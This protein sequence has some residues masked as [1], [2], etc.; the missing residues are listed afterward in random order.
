M[1]WY[2]LNIGYNWI[3]VERPKWFDRYGRKTGFIVYCLR[4]FLLLNWGRNLRLQQQEF[5][6]MCA[7]VFA[8]P[9]EDHYQ[10]IQI[11]PTPRCVS[12]GNWFLVSA[13]QYNSNI[14]L[15]WNNEPIR[16]YLNQLWFQTTIV[17]CLRL[18]AI[19]EIYLAFVS[20]NIHC[21]RKRGSFTCLV[22]TFLVHSKISLVLS[23]PVTTHAK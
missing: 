2:I 8:R 4:Y 20:N 21:I 15:L 1:Y 23:E 7:L 3:S 10:Q 17:Q 22:L 14:V 19:S 16:I 9:R 5:L 11:R 18:S 12:I 6:A 13:N